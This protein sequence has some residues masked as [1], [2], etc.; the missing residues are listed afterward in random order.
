MAVMAKPRRSPDPAVVATSAVLAGIGGLHVAWGLR[1][2]LPGVD[3]DRMAEAVVGSLDVPSPAACFAVAGL[4]GAAS[5][6]V[7]GVPARLP[8]IRRTGRLGVAAVLAGRG[9]LGLTGRTELVAP[10]P[11]SDRFRRWDRFVYTP[12]CLALAA[13][14][15]R[16]ATRPTAPRLPPTPS[17]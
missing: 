3:G 13:G 12:L 17:A 10:G 15:L 4:L 16:S 8:R 2:D 11:V 5:A 6:L 1:L 7:A 9:L 14:A